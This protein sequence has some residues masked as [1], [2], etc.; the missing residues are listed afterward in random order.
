MTFED[1]VRAQ[2]DFPEIR[3]SVQVEDDL[4]LF[5]PQNVEQWI[6][7]EQSVRLSEWE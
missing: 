5:N 6:Y 4:T 2:A 1:A 7:A 3:A